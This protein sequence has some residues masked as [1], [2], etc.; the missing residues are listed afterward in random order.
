MNK[1]TDVAKVMKI[2]VK[3]HKGGFESTKSPLSGIWVSSNPRGSC[4]SNAQISK[5]EDLRGDDLPSHLQAD[6]P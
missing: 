4:D 6:V 3:I 5:N 2:K 1:I